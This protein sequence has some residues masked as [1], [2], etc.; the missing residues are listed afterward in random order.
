MVPVDPASRTPA[1]LDDS[2]DA[3]LRVTSMRGRVEF[4]FELAAQGERARLEI[5][6]AAGRMRA[7]LVRGALGTGL[8]RI[9]WDGKDDA[10]RAVAP[11][12]YFAR[13][14]H[15]GAQVATARFVWFR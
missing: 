3:R 11:G 10:G 13:L 1:P 8:Y 12:V 9:G 7:T 6:D 15:G 5:Y 2:A 4:S 14:A